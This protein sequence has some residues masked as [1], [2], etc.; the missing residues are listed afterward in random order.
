[1]LDGLEAPDGP[2]GLHAYARVLDAELEDA[3]GGAHHLRRLRERAEGERGRDER[4][5]PPPARTGRSSASTATPSKVTSKSRSAAMLSSGERADPRSRHG[6][7]RG[8]EGA[9]AAH[10]DHVRGDVSI[11]DEE[12]APGDVPRSH[13]HAE[14]VGLEAPSLF[15]H[16]HRADALAEREARQQVGVHGRARPRPSRSGSRPPRSGCTGSAGTRGPS[17]RRAAIASRTEPPLPPCSAGIS[18]PGQ[19]S[20]AISFQRSSAKPRGSRASA[21]TRSGGQ[22]C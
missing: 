5:R 22:R 18:R 3:L 6:K 2:P 16:G 14:R 11:G 20:T 9:G 10:D 8:I 7:H 17:P 19:P 4:R 1:M 15:Q 21:C 12:L 13:A